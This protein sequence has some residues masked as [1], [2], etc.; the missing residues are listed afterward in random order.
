MQQKDD[1]IQPGGTYH[2]KKRMANNVLL[3]FFAAIAAINAA[4]FPAT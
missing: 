3:H 4:A 2:C 1:Q